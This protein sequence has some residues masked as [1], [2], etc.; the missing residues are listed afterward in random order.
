MAWTPAMLG[1]IFVLGMFLV[2]FGQSGMDKITDAKGN[3]EW[4]DGHFANSPFKG[5]VGVLL[6]AITLLELASAVLCGVGIVLLVTGNGTECAK[7]ALALCGL[8]LLCLF[9]GQR[10]AKDYA[11]AMTLAVYGGVLAVGFVA[12]HGA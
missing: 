3:R 6:P 7:W 2:A 1:A 8:T 11:G 12:L 4:L 5:M 9:A 10:L